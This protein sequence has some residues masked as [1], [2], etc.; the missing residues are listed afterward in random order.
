MPEG[1]D[2]DVGRDRLNQRPV[3]GEGRQVRV[4]AV[5]EVGRFGAVVRSPRRLVGFCRA[6][7]VD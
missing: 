2:G 6:G 1:R 5:A 3:A 4:N 7:N